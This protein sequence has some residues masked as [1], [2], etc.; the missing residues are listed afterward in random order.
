MH[1][2]P[3]DTAPVVRQ[4]SD[5]D[6]ML[7]ALAM[8]A[9]RGYE[10]TAAAARQAHP[11]FDS[12]RPMTHSLLRRV[13][14]QWG[15]VL[16]TSIYMDWRSPGIV[17]VASLTMEDCGH[18]LYWDGARLIDPG[19]SGLYDRDYVERGALEFTQRASDLGA[20]IVLD[21]QAQPA[22]ETT[23]LREFF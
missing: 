23:A 5:E 4:R 6:C 8:F 11:A 20:L 15:L 7:C 1:P 14:H 17:G 18:A 13:A 3:L 16:L 21:R 2:L 9:G 10:E 12:N 19:G 22:T